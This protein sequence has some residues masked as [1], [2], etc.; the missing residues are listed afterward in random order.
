MNVR[1][2]VFGGLVAGI[3]YNV[4]E[5]IANGVILGAEWKAWQISL[6]TADHP[7]APGAAIGL[8]T[9]IAFCWGIAG[10][11]LYAAIR[12]RFGAGPKSAIIAAS[13][14]WMIGWLFNELEQVALGDIPHHLLIIGS[15]AGLIASLAAV[16]TAAWI[17]REPA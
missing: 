15:L 9:L 4:I 7:P 11:W 14:L 3:I 6:G 5:T 10:A 1:R 8:W 2:I 12:P 13:V 17:Y 16:F